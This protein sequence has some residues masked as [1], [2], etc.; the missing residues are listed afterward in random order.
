MSVQS[1]LIVALIIVLYIPLFLIKGTYNSLSDLKQRADWGWTSLDSQLMRRCELVP[2]LLPTLQAHMNQDSEVVDVLDRAYA[3]LRRAQTAE[4]KI[5][6]NEELTLAI[7]RLLDA[8]KNFKDLMAD[9]NFLRLTDEI[10]GTQNRFIMARIRYN[11]RVNEYNQSLE[12]RP[13]SL[14]AGWLGFSPAVPYNVLGSEPN[15][16]HKG[17]S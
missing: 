14:L 11:N 17:E 1:K 16:P 6:A 2:E 3:G 15:T 8:A 10:E 4:Q 12:R 13:T 5:L 9:Q 7:G